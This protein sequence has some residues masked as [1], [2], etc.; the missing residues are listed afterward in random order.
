MPL[1]RLL[2]L[3]VLAVS[4]TAF[5]TGPT[6]ARFVKVPRLSKVIEFEMDTNVSPEEMETL[7]YCLGLNLAAQVR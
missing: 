6:P 7:L 1:Q 5:L 4:T 2:A 3:S